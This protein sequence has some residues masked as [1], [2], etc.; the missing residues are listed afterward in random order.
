MTDNGPRINLS[1][2]SHGFGH[3]SQIMA[4]ANSLI[5]LNPDCFFKIQTV[6]SDKQI[7]EKIETKNFEIDHSELDVGLIQ[8]SPFHVDLAKTRQAYNEFHD[9]Y[10]SKVKSEALKL[11]NWKPDIVI[12]DI[13]YLSLAASAK[14]NIPNVALASL[15]WDKVIPAYFDPKDREVRQWLSDIISSQQDTMLALLPTPSME[16]DSF[17]TIEKIPPV[18][19]KGKSIKNFR[20]RLN[21]DENDER[22][23]ILCHFGGLATSNH[24]FRALENDQNF[25]WLSNIAFENKQNHL[26]E[27]S[28]LSNTRFKDLIASVDGLV[29]KPGYATAVESVHYNIPFL[30]SLRG[31]FPDEPIITDWLSKTKNAK[32]INKVDWEVGSILT[33]LFE[34]T[35]KLPAKN[36]KC[37]GA[38]IA[39]KIIYK[40]L[41]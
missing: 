25:H 15:S 5:E 19:L 29:G 41:P 23:V 18:V 38:E 6:F 8:N 10:V 27:V 9:D 7:A 26:H 12:A 36:I 1:I 33:T 34:L 20:T 16:L 39:A 35:D 11:Q 13:P 24:T 3:L 30:Y 2:S 28:T 4:V 22:K 17:R 31:D 14:V 37:N 32:E 40:F 21:I